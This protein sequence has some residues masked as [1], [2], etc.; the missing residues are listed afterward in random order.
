[1]AISTKEADKSKA[2]DVMNILGLEREMDKVMGRRYS[3]RVVHAIGSMGKVIEEA[4]RRG[5]SVP[6][7]KAENESGKRNKEKAERL[8]RVYASL[9]KEFER[10]VEEE[11]GPLRYIEVTDIDDIEKRYGL[12]FDRKVHFDIDTKMIPTVIGLT[13]P[14]PSPT[15]AMLRVQI[16][17]KTEHNMDAAREIVENIL[18]TLEAK[19]L[20]QGMVRPD[21]IIK[22]AGPRRGR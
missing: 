20:L 5:L 13:S 19:K 1:M 12:G 6:V 4:Y 7:G 18:A 22:P 11:D 2:A 8:S 16:L 14:M 17:K 10:L 15:P 3:D 9:I 21:Q